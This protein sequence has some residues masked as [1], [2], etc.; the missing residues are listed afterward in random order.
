MIQVSLK[1]FIRT[2]DFAGVRLGSTEAEVKALLGEPDDVG[3]TS[4]RQRRPLIWKYGDFEFHF[5]PDGDRL[6]MIF[7]DEFDIPRGGRTLALDPWI[8]RRDLP[9][10]ELVSALAALK[11][12]PRVR[13]DTVLEAWIVT[14]SSGVTFAY[15]A[16]EDH[17]TEGSEAS[18]L[19]DLRVLHL[20]S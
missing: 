5:P 8:I 11:L 14:A 13:E 15:H 18:G 3:G 12:D 20:G 17:G 7:I 10:A 16:A 9:R 2:G 4:R 1:D 19:E 6:W